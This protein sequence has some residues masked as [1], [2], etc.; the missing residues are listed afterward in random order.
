MEESRVPSK[1][2][3]RDDIKVVVRNRKA[4]HLYE[5]IDSFEAGLVLMGSEVKSLRAG[6]VS[7]SDAY[8]SPRGQEYFLLNLHISSYDKASVDPHEP[9]R[10][11]KL[12]LHKRQIRRLLVRV[13]ERGLTLIPLQIYFR[14]GYAKVEIAVVRGKR[15][16]DK[17]EAIAKR[18]AMRDL[19]RQRAARERG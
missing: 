16:Y 11:R 15:K 6:K 4:R 12:M 14:G 2:P 5:I 1:K 19:D 9:L 13:H 10:P 8:A 18:D 3:D 17:R 7:L